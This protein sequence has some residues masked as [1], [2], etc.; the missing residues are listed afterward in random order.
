[1]H[2]IIVI[3]II[4]LFKSQGYL[5]EHKC[6]TNWED[7]KSTEIRRKSKQMLVFEERGNPAETQPACGVY[8][9][10]QSLA[11]LVAGECSHHCAS[12][13]PQLSFLVVV[14]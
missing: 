2:L 9:E 10:N 7:Y 13:A 5:A 12:P 14:F 6:S 8:S 4:T 1:M 3:I 11:T